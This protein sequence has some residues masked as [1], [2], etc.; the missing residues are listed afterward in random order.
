MVSVE[1]G[2]VARDL[3]KHLMNPTLNFT[4]DITP[5]EVKCYVSVMF[6]GS[7]AD[8]LSLD[9]GSPSETAGGGGH[10]GGQE[11][12]FCSTIGL[13]GLTR[14]RYP[15]LHEK[16]GDTALAIRIRPRFRASIGK[17]S[18]GDTGSSPACWRATGG[19]GT[20]RGAG[21]IRAG[22]LGVYFQYSRRVS[23][24]DSRGAI[25]EKRRKS[26]IGTS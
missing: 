13:T 22:A 14:L 1:F 12:K 3:G 7:S 6:G 17:V 23:C 25:R 11:A 26:G 2:D 16:R 10:A 19:A 9:E 20:N 15:E 24:A 4:P 5:G 21:F 8:R 18:G